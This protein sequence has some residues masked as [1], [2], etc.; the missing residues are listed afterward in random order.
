MDEKQLKAM[1][2]LLDDPDD[3]IFFK[4]REELLAVG[5]PVIPVLEDTWENLF[6]QRDTKSLELL[7]ARIETLIH[8]IQLSSTIESLS[9][10]VDTG[11]SLLDGALLVAQYQYPDLKEEK[12]H[13]TIN[14]L[15]NEVATVLVGKRSPKQQVD[16]MNHVLFGVNGFKG[17]A[18]NFH[19]PQNSFITD[20]LENKRGNPLSLS[21]LYIVI[22][23]LVGL[24][25][26][27]VN[28]PRHF[29]VA[30]KRSN[31]DIEFYINPF[32]RGSMFN[33][34]DITQF[35]QQLE[36]ESKA[37]YYE[38]C[39]NADMIERSLVNLEYAYEKLG[40]AQKVD[41]IRMLIK[42]MV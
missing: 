4:I 35:L 23:R 26:Y 29:I 17:N 33:K 12:I 41:E 3:G 38:T 25:L 31:E 37:I 7:Q 20:V 30:F 9:R 11:G 14:Q 39:S 8:D 2:Y 32:S 22:G 16:A 42:A 5:D 18:K 24:P 34:N 15:K 28:L 13:R 1:I 19:A 21:I 10:W 36:L 40:Y 6:S 27:G